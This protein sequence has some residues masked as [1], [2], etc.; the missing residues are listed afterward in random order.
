M[1]WFVCGELTRR[2]KVRG[3]SERWLMRVGKKAKD[4]LKQLK[5]LFEL[6]SPFSKTS[7]VLAVCWGRG[8]DGDDCNFSPQGAGG[9]GSRGL[10]QLQCWGFSV[11]GILCPVSFRGTS[12][13]FGVFMYYKIILKIQSTYR[14]P[15]SEPLCGR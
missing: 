6:V 3:F 9:V 8:K 5:K 11:V 7:Y 12:E 10:R 14:P 1:I 13:R 4:F 15:Q 2:A